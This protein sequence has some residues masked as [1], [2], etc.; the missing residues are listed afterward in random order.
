MFSD[1]PWV[2]YV[3]MNTVGEISI[4]PREYLGHALTEGRLAVPS[5]QR[6]YAWKERHVRDLFEDAAIVLDGRDNSEYF[7]GTIVVM[8]NAERGR[9]SD[10]IEKQQRIVVDGQQ[11]LAT[12]QIFLAAV[13]DYFDRQHNTNQKDSI[14]SEF[15]Y[16]FDKYAEKN[17]PHFH[18]NDADDDFFY[19]RVLLPP[20]DALRASAKPIRASHKL[21]DGAAQV[22]AE[23]VAKIVRDAR[24][25]PD[26]ELKRWVQF[27]ERKARVIWVTVGDEST[28]YIIFETMNDRGLELSATDLIKNYLFRHAGNKLSAVQR[29]W[30][31]ILGALE[32]TQAQELARDFIR[33]YWIS[34]HGTTRSSQLFSA[35]KD[36]VKSQARAVALVNDLDASTP[37]YMAFQNARGAYWAGYDERTKQSIE[38]LNSFGARQIRPLL[39]AVLRR[40]VKREVQKV[41]R[42]AVSWNVRLVVTELLGRSAVET[43]YGKV[44]FQVEQGKVKTAEELS[45]ELREVIPADDVFAVNFRKFSVKDAPAR[46]ILAQLEVAKRG[47]QNAAMVPNPDA[48]ELNLEH[49]LPRNRSE[50]TWRQFKDEEYEEYKDR[51]GNLA[52]MR[53]KQ[54]S[55]FG[56]AEFAVKRPI[57]GKEDL[58]LTKEIADCSDW[59]KDEIEKRQERLAELAV[60]TWPLR[61]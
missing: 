9:R 51:L 42:L 58:L 37:A 28:A 17:E 15:L 38:A 26:A 4:T 13:R 11:R 39:L 33:H 36:D 35:I 43:G 56:N 3:R 10:N 22:A 34:K 61:A 20:D 46:F 41:V 23:W 52:L 30:S 54:N 57:L 50:G 31:A 18:L 14:Q 7:L 8:E 24:R 21:I 6:E 27:F 45:H 53:Q 48:K 47:S 40:F 55:Q 49:I 12:T 44:A 2:R 32:S 25:D 16:S 60:K 1:N 29:K 5:N 19:K 59:R